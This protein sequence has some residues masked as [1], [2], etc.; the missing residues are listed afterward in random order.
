MESNLMTAPHATSSIGPALFHDAIASRPQSTGSSERLPSSDRI[1]FATRKEEQ[2]L[3]ERL[4]AIDGLRQLQDNWDS[5]GARKVDA[6]SIDSA[7][8][9]V[10]W[11]STIVGVNRPQV[12]ASPDGLV[13]LS[14]EWDDF[15]KNLDVV[16]LRP[17]FLQFCYVDERDDS[18]SM[19]GTTGDWLLIAGIL[20]QW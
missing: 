13:G 18:N 6:R 14:W 11:L 1:Y 3:D 7:R 9:F 4:D 17:G 10:R 2:W 19:E 8:A 15:N 20:T 12:A 5:Y 16:V